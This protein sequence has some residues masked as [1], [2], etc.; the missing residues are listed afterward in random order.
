MFVILPVVKI[1]DATELYT[2]TLAWLMAFNRVLLAS[3]IVI[4]RTWVELEISSSGF[5]SYL[6]G[7]LG[8]YT[9]KSP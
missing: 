8:V 4:L 2:L 9:F 5:R 6:L 3:G 1:P 7:N